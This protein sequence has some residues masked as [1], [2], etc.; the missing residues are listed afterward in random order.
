M[1]EPVYYELC[2]KN[3]GDVAEVYPYAIHPIQG[4]VLMKVDGW[5][6]RVYGEGE[7]KVTAMPLA[8]VLSRFSGSVAVKM[9]CEGCEESLLYT[10]CDLIRRSDEYIVE[11]HPNV[12]MNGILSYMKSCGFEYKPKI[13]YSRD[14]A[15]YHFSRK[16]L[17]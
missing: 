13:I 9:D 12:D 15:I 16:H 17:Q 11:I 10:P 6:S 5:G 1:F 8:N 7:I 3:V 4:E 2:V 14:L